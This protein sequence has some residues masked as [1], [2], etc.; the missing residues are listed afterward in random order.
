MDDGDLALAVDVR[1]RVG[2][3]GN[4]VGGPPRVSDPHVAF[5]RAGGE[6][7]L[8]VGDFAGGFTGLDTVAVHHRNAGRVVAAVFHALESLEQKGSRAT[9]SDVTNNSA[10]I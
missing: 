1:M 9:V 10:H 3:I 4:T 6:R 7:P 2:F 5:Y 8:E